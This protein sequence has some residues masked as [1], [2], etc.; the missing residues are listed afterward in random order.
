MKE[1]R[2][3]SED[4]LGRFF[5]ASASQEESRQ[6]VRHLVTGCPRCTELAHRTLHEL[7]LGSSG[8]PIW[9]DA[10]EQVFQRAF[11]F[12][13]EEE[14]QTA[15]ERLRGW[16]QW[17]ALEPLNPQARL[18]LVESDPR[19]HTLGLFD[20][21]L[22]ASRF[23]ARREP[24]EGV[25]IVRLAIAVAERLIPRGLDEKQAGDLQAT[26]WAELGNARRLA[27]DFEEARAAFN[28]AWRLFEEKGT[29]DPLKRAA[30]I[31]LEA[32]YI[33][34]IGEFETAEATLEEALQLY[35]EAGDLHLQ[36]RTLIQMADFI[37][38][39]DPVKGISHIRKALPLI[40][41]EREPR[42]ELCAQHDLAWF[43]NDDGRPEEALAVLEQ[44]RPLYQQL[45]DAY[46][47]LR[48]HWL[49]ARIAQNLGHQEEAESTFQ[50]LWDEFRARDLR[51]ELVLVSIDLAELFVEKGETGRAM[52]LVAQTHPILKGW[53]LHRYA[54]A[55]WLF[56][57]RGLAGGQ[58]E[59]VFRQVREYYLRRWSRPGRLES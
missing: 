22:E 7:G 53:G 36:G 32:S 23:Y 27:A 50:Q 35:A 28:E 37:G 21:L 56:F 59:E 16:G 41:I 8:N 6:V 51:H 34:E 47:Q 42:L 52:E 18:A 29:G 1:D 57:Q 10:Y 14:R 24:A 13:T 19:F 30:L 40:E 12:A 31:S 25:D 15:L 20:R 5:Q 26:A 49:E 44:A 3:I 54:L 58:A 17:A 55:A 39:V 48:L 2:H 45:P 33:D 11:L 38:K 43:L 46:T 9:E 4:L